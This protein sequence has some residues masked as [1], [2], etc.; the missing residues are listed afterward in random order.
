MRLG[1]VEDEGGSYGTMVGDG[2]E[3]G[4][5]RDS[6]IGVGLGYGLGSGLGSVWSVDKLVGPV[7]GVGSMGEAVFRLW[8]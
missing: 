6:V 4:K 8:A 1:K 7:F 2:S 5:F 3:G